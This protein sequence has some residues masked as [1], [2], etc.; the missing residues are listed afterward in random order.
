M[1][2]KRIYDSLMEFAK[3]RKEPNGYSEKHH[4]L[5]KSLGGNDSKE[6]IVK[7]T[8]KEHIFAHKLLIKF[9]SGEDRRKMQRAYFFMFYSN[10]PRRELN[11][12]DQAYAREQ[13]SIS[14]RG[15]PSSTKG[16]KL[17]ISDEHRKR[18]AEI[19]LKNLENADNSGFVVCK[20]LDTK[21]TV[22][23]PIEVFREDSNLVGLNYG[24]TFGQREGISWLEHMPSEED[25]KRAFGRSG[26]ENGASSK[27]SLERYGRMTE[28]EFKEWCRDKS[29]RGIKR[30]T[31]FR[32]QY[33]ESVSYG[34]R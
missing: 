8:A 28:E 27:K 14:K 13:C 15:V 1:D 18:L 6:N 11:L 12:S 21:E 29:A 34:Q 2:Y 19:G 23:V 16:M 24:N 33:Q 31:T 10:N 32:K 4:I 17:N 30:A 20:T 7:L 22:R 3:L 9:T 5:P 26:D 25:R